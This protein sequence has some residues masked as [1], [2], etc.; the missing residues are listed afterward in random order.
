MTRLISALL[1][2][3]CSLSAQQADPANDEQ[4]ARLKDGDMEMRIGALRELQTSLDRRLPEAFLPLL[5]D[6]G[7]S[8]RRLA[9]RGVGSRYWQI[10]DGRKPAFLKALARNL[11]S[12]REDERN[13]AAR[14][15]GL[16]TQKYDG[17]MFGRSPDGRWVIYERHGLPCLID[18]GNK[19]EELLGWDAA[20]RYE[21]QL[22]SAWGNGV[23]ERSVHWHPAE[24]IVALD[25][26]I[27]RKES[28][29][30][31]WRHMKGVKKFDAGALR[32]TVGYRD[33]EINRGAGI[34]VQTEA[35]H[36]N[37]LRI[38]ADFGL[39]RGDNYID[40]SAVFGWDMATDALRMI[41]KN[42]GE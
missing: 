22:A 16:L 12:E 30:W 8:I 27:N 26:L 40:V 10:S 11:V 5:A 42:E 21:G 41:S 13:M 7:N 34:Y 28:T 38:S 31:V 14:A 39:R 18:T 4:I 29:V 2:F 23:V 17:A 35:W 37:E 9:A 24:E 3:P 1:L 25:I 19:T 32:N 33:D 20:S 36:G 15:I 6:E